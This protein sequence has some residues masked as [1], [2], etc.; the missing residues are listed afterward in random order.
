MRNTLISWWIRRRFVHLFTPRW[1]DFLVGIR[2]SHMSSCEIVAEDWR[3]E[4]LKRANK[5]A[6]QSFHFNL[7][8]A[9]ANDLELWKRDTQLVSARKNFINFLAWHGASSERWDEKL[10]NTPAFLSCPPPMSIGRRSF[11]RFSMRLSS[12]LKKWISRLISKL[13]TE[14]HAKLT[15]IRCCQL[16]SVYNV[17]IDFDIFKKV[18]FFVVG[19]AAVMVRLPCTFDTPARRQKKHKLSSWQ[20]TARLWMRGRDAT[21]PSRKTSNN[22]VGKNKHFICAHH[23]F[24]IAAAAETRALFQCLRIV[25]TAKLKLR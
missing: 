5:S 20:V 13:H 4:Y 12:E 25:C 18:S 16:L 1:L 24:S 22:N 7:F 11:S 19:H 2:N 10:C 21:E 3:V 8:E 15:R 17:K 9:S 23:R 6:V 14:K